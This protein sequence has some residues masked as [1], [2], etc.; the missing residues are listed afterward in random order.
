LFY[1][2]QAAD[3]AAAEAII[4]AATAA[5]PNLALV[6]SADPEAPWQRVVSFVE[7]AQKTGADSFSFTMKGND[8]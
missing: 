2:G 1:Q 5:R 7:T 4:R 6:L 8:P 3:A